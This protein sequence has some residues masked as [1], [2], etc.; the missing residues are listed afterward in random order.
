MR[1][2]VYNFIKALK[3]KDFKLAEHLPWEA[4]G[5][6]LYLANKKHI[7][8]ETA[9]TKQDAMYN[10]LGSQGTVDEITT[11]KVYF[12]NDAKILP[13]GY[14]SAVNLIKGARLAQGSEGYVSRTCQVSTAFQEDALVTTFEFSFR[15]LLTN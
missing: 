14:D 1:S 2:V 11:V 7:Y 9:Q 8:V 6:A 3:L 15:K 12:V 4:D 13:E 10:T 5:T